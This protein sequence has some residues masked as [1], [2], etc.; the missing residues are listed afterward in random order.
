MKQKETSVFNS[1]VAFYLQKTPPLVINQSKHSTCG[2]REDAPMCAL[3]CRSTGTAIQ[4]QGVVPSD[5][6]T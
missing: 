4:Q 6:L 2:G 3:G 5:G 1:R